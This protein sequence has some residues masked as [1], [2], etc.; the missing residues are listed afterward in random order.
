MK[1]NHLLCIILLIATSSCS[2]P[3]NEALQELASKQ[4]DWN[5]VNNKE[6]ILLDTTPHY[7]QALFIEN[8]TNSKYYDIILNFESS[9][10]KDS[11]DKYY[12]ESIKK[13]PSQNFNYNFIG[14]WV[15][16]NKFNNQNYLYIPANRSTISRI[17]LKNDAII[18]FQMDGIFPNLIRKINHRRNFVELEVKG[19]AH[20]FGNFNFEEIWKLELIDSLRQI[21]KVSIFKDGELWEKSKFMIPKERCKEYPIVVN[22]TDNPVMAKELK[23]DSF[24]K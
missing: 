10:F 9:S 11:F 16:I 12:Q 5:I 22:Y 18:T 8:D 24:E 6:L 23:F 4:P 15:E 3:D 2:S 1:A 7:F 14:D 17:Q 13:Y 21:I 20:I 19:P